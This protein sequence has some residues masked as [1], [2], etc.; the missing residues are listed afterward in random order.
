MP[1]IKATY[2]FGENIPFQ[3]AQ[4]ETREAILN[5]LHYQGPMTVNQ[6]SEAIGIA[7]SVIHGHVKTL[8]EY[9]LV[10]EVKAED[11]RKSRIEKYFDLNIPV[12][13]L[14]DQDRFQ[15]L[16]EGFA[17]KA[18]QT[19]H[20]YVEEV[21]SQEEEFDFEGKGWSVKN[22]AISRY[23]FIELNH[24]FDNAL[25]KTGILGESSPGPDRRGK[26]KGYLW[27]TE[28]VEDEAGD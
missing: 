10:R 5:K 28:Y 17:Q 6:L 13:T 9:D 15:R 22:P 11:R 16:A 8:E 27:C 23:V 26:W 1:R 20:G 19:I 21:Q 18:A 3:I 12:F 14:K 25:T 4:Q 7:Q 24:A 2:G